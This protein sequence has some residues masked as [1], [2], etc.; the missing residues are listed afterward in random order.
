MTPADGM[1]L[2]ESI[3]DAFQQTAVSGPLLLALGAAA[4]ILF[5][6]GAALGDCAQSVLAFPGR[7]P[8]R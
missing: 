1:V 6:V 5:G 8:A 4:A 2:A 7:R 3:G